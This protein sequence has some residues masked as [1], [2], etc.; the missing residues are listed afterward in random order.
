MDEYISVS[1]FFFLFL[2]EFALILCCIYSHAIVV[3]FSPPSVSCFLLCNLTSGLEI[4][5]SF[6][7]RTMLMGLAEFIRELLIHAHC[8]MGKFC[9]HGCI[10]CLHKIKPVRPTLLSAFLSIY[11]KNPALLVPTNLSPAPLFN[12]V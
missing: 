11:W 2:L 6:S 9:S 3:F 5:C 10:Q 12:T 1:P 4:M 7:V 8:Q